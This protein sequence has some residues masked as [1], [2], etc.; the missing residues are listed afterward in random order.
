MNIFNSLKRYAESWHESSKRKFT[1]EEIASIKEAKVIE[2]K[3]GFS[4]CFVL[5]EGGQSYIPLDQ[6]SSLGVG[7][8]V[9]VTTAWL[10]T[11]SRSGEED[12][13]RVRP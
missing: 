8:T 6:N 5:V 10:I 4:V 13:K 11:L 1:P 9:D 3:Y 7:D 2:S 12:I